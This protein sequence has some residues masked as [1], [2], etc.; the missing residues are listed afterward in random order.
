MNDVREMAAFLTARYPGIDIRMFDDTTTPAA[1]TKAG[2]MA[3][4]RAF[5]DSLNADTAC[6]GAWIHY[7]GH[8]S[9]TRDRSGDEADGKDEA[10]VPTDFQTAGL[11]LDDE[12]RAVFA[13]VTR[14]NLKIVCVMDSC[15]SGTV[16]DLKYLW[17]SK[18]TAVLENKAA[19]AIQPRIILLSGC[20]DAQTSADAFDV[21]GNKQAG[22]ALTGN[23]LHAFRIDNA[24]NAFDVQQAVLKR[25]KDGGFTQRPLLTSSYNL[26]K[27]L[28][29]L[30]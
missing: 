8:G 25:L 26:A 17:T 12:L 6:T 1:C 13:G 22:G 10:L 28:V 23:L 16:C 18:T 24:R 27:D 4:L 9:T 3:Q 21:L 14:K 5:V 29:M 7:S 15:H 20:M 11:I 2:I 30:P 19:P